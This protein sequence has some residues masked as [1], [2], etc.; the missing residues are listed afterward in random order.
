MSG[1]LGGGS[2]GLAGRRS[3]GGARGGSPLSHR[4]NALLFLLAASLIALFRLD[5]LS[6]PGEAAPVRSPVAVSRAGRLFVLVIDSLRWE[7]AMNPDLMPGLERL[8]Q[9]GAWARIRTTRD[10]VTVPALRAAFTGRD[11][12]AVSGVV[13]NFLHG[14]AGLESVFSEA[15]A[16]GLRAAAWSDGSFLQFGAGNLDLLANEEAGDDEVVRQDRAFRAALEDFRAGRHDLVVVHLT[17]GD[18]RAHEG[19]TRAPH[20]AETFRHLD[21][22]VAEADAGVGADETL[23]VMG[24]HGHDVDGRHT[25]GLEVPTLAVYRGRAHPPGADLGTLPILALR[26]LASRALGLPGAAAAQPEEESGIPARSRRD[27]LVLAACLGILGLLWV[28][29]ALDLLAGPGALAAWLAVL[30]LGLP[31]PLPWALVAVAASALLSL[32]AFARSGP[33]WRTRLAALAGAVALALLFVAW[34]ITFVSVRGLLHHPGPRLLAAAWLALLAASCAAAR[35]WGA[36]PAVWLVP[37]AALLLLFPTAYPY[38]GPSFLAAAWII[39]IVL[40]RAVREPAVPAWRRGRLALALGA[41][42]LLS[43]FLFPDT[44]NFAFER[45]SLA[46]VALVP[47]GWV[48]LA[49][50]ALVLLFVGPGSRAGGVRPHTAMALACAAAVVVWIQWRGPLALGAELA[51]AAAAAFAAALSRGRVSAPVQRAAWLVAGLLATHAL[52][53]VPPE[54]HLWFD[55][56]LLAGALSGELLRR[57]APPGEALARSFLLVLG[58]MAVGWCMSAWSMSRLEW[59]FLYR[60]LDQA[61]LERNVGWALPLI[62]ARFA[63]PVALLRFA[64]GGGADQ[65]GSTG[66]LAALFLGAKALTV[67]LV[68]L[69]TGWVSVKSDLYL[70]AFQHA[71]VWLLL[72]T[73]VLAWPGGARARAE[74]I[75]IAVA[76]DDEATHPVAGH[77]ALTG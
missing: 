48:G 67:L 22:L 52:I 53:K 11:R 5:G 35:R 7:T 51:T 2:A 69:G 45:W 58:A 43:Q 73:G 47:H 68:A 4:L 3:L 36:G 25:L 8:R 57:V 72:A 13:R 33:S 56:F 6:T 46:A 1:S 75:P 12:L 16:A 55:A 60:F 24:D 21:A 28:S 54:H 10:A 44:H 15:R 38:G 19:G 62:L 63:I 29:L 59:T 34:G 71:G 77:E 70:E 40:Q 17:Y 61:T 50:V 27:A 26:S 39:W 66:R 20:Y 30:A 49:G 23:S 31:W 42:A 41:A 65:G 74:D 37:G 64:I 9:R 14:E 18:H 76:H 32:G